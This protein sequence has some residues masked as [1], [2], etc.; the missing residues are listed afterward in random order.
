MNTLV[1]INWASYNEPGNKTIK[2]V[3]L[4]EDGFIIAQEF[5]C[6]K[7]E[8]RCTGRWSDGDISRVDKWVEAP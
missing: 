7:P 4:D 5:I 3:G 2:A 1:N 6:D 8:C